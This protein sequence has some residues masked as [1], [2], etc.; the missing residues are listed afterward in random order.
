MKIFK[1]ISLF[2]MLF[3]ALTS[4]AQV[5]PKEGY[6]VTNQQDTIYGLVDFRTNEINSKQCYFKAND[7][8]EFVKYGPTDIT[9]YR[10]KESGKYY[11]SK[12]FNNEETFFAEFLVKGM[13][14]LY[15]K[16]I[17]SRRI[18][19]LEN[20]DGNVVSYEEKKMDSDY[21]MRMAKAN[22]QTLFRQVEKSQNAVNDI[23]IGEMNVKRMIKMVR[24]YHEDVC[25]SNTECIQFE[26]E[27]KS[28]KT[29]WSPTIY[30]GESNL[31][32]K[33]NSIM[34]D[35]KNSYGFVIGAGVDFDRSRSAR[36]K[37]FQ[38]Y[39]TYSRLYTSSRHNNYPDIETFTMDEFAIALGPMYRFPIKNKLHF[40]AN[41]GVSTRSYNISYSMEGTKY[42]GNEF[43]LCVPYVGCG[44]ELPIQK[45][46]L[47]FNI[48]LRGIG[49]SDMNTLQA[50]VGFRI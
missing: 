7:A 35:V 2:A 50:I 27:P 3:I 20:Q 21:D 24:D 42:K 30:V 17:D 47:N 15:R 4:Y 19:Y 1:G 45:H 32:C 46:A 18:Y 26:H 28:D 8:Q 36:G 10:F 23:K 41:F 34:L 38:L 5:N 25:T 44:L 40:T 13:L 29:K 16:E 9:A 14:N 49:I 43:L 6:I 33:K 39:I 12:K 11:V 22:A 37:L 48:E 31:F